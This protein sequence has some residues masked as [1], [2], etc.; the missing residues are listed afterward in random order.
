MLPSVAA[1]VTALLSERVKRRAGET[2]ETAMSSAFARLRH[3]L[4]APVEI[5]RV[6]V[7]RQRAEVVFGSKTMLASYVFLG[8]HGGSWRLEDPLGAT[9]P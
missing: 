6:R 4:S 2:C 9:L 5:T 8:R 7:D 3:E 1:T